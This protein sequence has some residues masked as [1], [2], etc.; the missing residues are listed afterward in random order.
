MKTGRIL[1]SHEGLV[2]ALSSSLRPY[3]EDFTRKAVKQ[4]VCVFTVQNGAGL[5][6]AS[7]GGDPARLTVDICHQVRE[8]GRPDQARLTGD[9]T[10][11][12][13]GDRHRRTLLPPGSFID[14]AVSAARPQ[15]NLHI[16]GSEGL[17]SIGTKF[18]TVRVPQISDKF[19]IF[20]QVEGAFGRFSAGSNACL[21][22]GLN[23]FCTV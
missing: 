18:I 3:A 9:A 1:T 6:A 4:T 19:T 12:R 8:S 20:T 11:H 7:E 22:P 21:V 14:G 5:P 13:S 15:A 23:I 17:L 2:K 10:D 16:P